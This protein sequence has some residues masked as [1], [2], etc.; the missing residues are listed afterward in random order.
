L[1]DLV[2]LAMQRGWKDAVY[3]K[4]SEQN[5]NQPHWFQVGIK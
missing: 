2:E 3:E 4:Q 5:N 1:D